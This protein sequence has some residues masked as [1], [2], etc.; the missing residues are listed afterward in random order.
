M[1]FSVSVV[2][3]GKECVLAMTGEGDGTVSVSIGTDEVFSSVGIFGA[4]ATF[5]SAFVFVLVHAG[6]LSFDSTLIEMGDSSTLVRRRLASLALIGDDTM[7][8]SVVERR[9]TCVTLNDACSFDANGGV[10]S[11]GTTGSVA[12]S[13]LVAVGAAFGVVLLGG[14]LFEGE[15]CLAIRF[16]LALAFAAERD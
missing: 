3:D 6:S 15:S 2:V 8:D 14:R 9:L 7:D 5:G 4:F 10:F 12:F 11:A 13:A 16:P 1:V